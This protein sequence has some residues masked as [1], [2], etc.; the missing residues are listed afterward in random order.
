MAVRIYKTLNLSEPTSES[1]RQF[2]G[3][4]EGEQQIDGNILE[5][6]F[7]VIGDVK[8]PQAKDAKCS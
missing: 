7:R 3:Y 6:L 2:G 8:I 1:V 4:G 5:I